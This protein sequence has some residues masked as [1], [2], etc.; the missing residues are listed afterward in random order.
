M[1]TAQRQCPACGPW[2]EALGCLTLASLSWPPPSCWSPQPSLPRQCCRTSASTRC[3]PCNGTSGP[4]LT[5]RPGVPPA[6]QDQ[7]H[8]RVL[9]GR[10]AAKVRAAAARP[11]SATLHGLP[12]PCR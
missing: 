5:A 12:Q 8:P 4:R 9:D 6:P 10:R 2:T 7:W 11:K 1:S 3:P